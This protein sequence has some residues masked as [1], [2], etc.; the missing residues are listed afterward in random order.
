[1]SPDVTCVDDEGSF[2]YLRQQY[3]TDDGHSPTF[4]P[5]DRNVIVRPL[6]EEYTHAHNTRAECERS[7]GLK[8]CLEKSFSAEQPGSRAAVSTIPCGLCVVRADR[9][10]VTHL[11]SSR[12]L[13]PIRGDTAS[14][15]ET[16]L[17]S[18]NFSKLYICPLRYFFLANLA[19]QV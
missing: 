3:P 2:R 15:T 13:L 12:S 10:A 17:S 6:D 4:R 18:L 7:G 16:L 11:A 1:M 8:G 14:R 19:E 5:S 9:P